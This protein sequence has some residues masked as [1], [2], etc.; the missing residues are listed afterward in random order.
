MHPLHALSQ[1]GLRTPGQF[2][3]YP[4]GVELLIEIHE[5]DHCPGER[6]LASAQAR[7]EFGDCGRTV[8]HGPGYVPRGT[9][10]F[11]CVGGRVEEVL[12]RNQFIAGDVVDSTL[13]GRVRAIQ[14]WK[15]GMAKPTWKV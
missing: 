1:T 13:G 12:L 4:T 9:R 8:R 11:Q 7:P 10:Q 2:L 3:A 6:W 15:R 14:G 5:T